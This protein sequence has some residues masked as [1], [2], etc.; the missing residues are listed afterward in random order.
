VTAPLISAA[1]AA[2]IVTCVA[3]EQDCAGLAISAIDAA[4]LEIPVNAYVFTMGSGIP[5]A[6]IRAYDRGMDV[7]GAPCVQQEGVGA[8]AGA[9][10]PVWIDARARVAHEKVLIMGR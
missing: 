1:F 9:G 6:L 3:P 2:S 7:P 4:R 8:A 10:V 5:A